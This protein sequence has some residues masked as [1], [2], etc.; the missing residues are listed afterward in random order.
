MPKLQEGENLVKMVIPLRNAYRAPR[1]KRAKVAIRLIR[2]LVARHFHYDGTIKIGEKLNEMI[3]GRSI[4][5]P[6][7]RVEV[8]VKV[9]VEEGKPV[10]VSVD[11]PSKESEE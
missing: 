9:N 7:R 4:E 10:E 11:L 2:E 6:P 5:K 3:W 8:A 1:K